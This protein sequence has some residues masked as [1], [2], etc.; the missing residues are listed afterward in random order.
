MRPLP[1]LNQSDQSMYQPLQWDLYRALP[2]D[3]LPCLMHRWPQYVLLDRSMFRLRQSDRYQAR[4]SDPLP[5]L[6]RQS[7]PLPCLMRQSDP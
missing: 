3:L 7:D 6:M 4:Q 5:C 2:L 1:P